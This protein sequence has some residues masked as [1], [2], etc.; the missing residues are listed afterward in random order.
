M[1]FGV[2]GGDVFVWRDGARV[3]EHGDER[4]VDSTGAGDALTATLTA[5]LLRGGGPEEAAERAVAAAGDSVQ[6]LGGR[7]HLPRLPG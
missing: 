1:T 4:V 2:H 3:F 5:V 7:P 6:H